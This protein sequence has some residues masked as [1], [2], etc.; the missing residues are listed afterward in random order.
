MHGQE[1]DRGTDVLVGQRSLHLIA[2]GKRDPHHVEVVCVHVAIIAR[3]PVDALEVGEAL[4]VERDVAP[5]DL[6]VPTNLVELHERDRRK[7][8]AEI[9]FV[10]GHCDVVEGPVA[11][12]HHTQVVEPFREIVSVR[13]DQPALAGGDVLGR[14]E[15]EAGQVRDRPD[16]AAAVARLRG[17][18][19]VLHDRHAEL[20]QL[21]EIGRL[22][23]EIDRD[24]RLR[25]L[26]DE[27]A[28]PVGIDVQR[29]VAN[30]GEH[31][32]GA[33]MDD[34]VRGRRPGDR[35]RDHLVA[36]ADPERDEGEVQGRC[37]GGDGEHV[38][39]LQVLA[40][41]GLQLGRPRSRRQ[42]ARSQG[43]CDGIDLRFG[44]RRGLE[45]KE[46]SSLGGEL[47]HPR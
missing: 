8:V 33:A 35:G 17:M 22:A 27:L 46:L 4:V 7:D 3:D 2:I 34:H 21:V 39:R 47:R 41:P 36:G 24:D 38:L 5:P 44:D 9:R 28:Y 29:V 32:C 1:V 15:G 19:G 12:P 43:L 42:P 11:A 40:H 45:R 30:I 10:P 20:G 6:P 16:L 23:V 37:A 14:V 26:T 31:G 13:G 18:C 25:S